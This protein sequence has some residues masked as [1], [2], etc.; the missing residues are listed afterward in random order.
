[1]EYRDEQNKMAV[2]DLNEI[3]TIV[4][5]FD[6]DPE[7]GWGLRGDAYLWNLLQAKMG[8]CVP[9]STA[10]GLCRLIEDIYEKITG[11]SVS[12]SGRLSDDGK[13]EDP[14]SFFKDVG[15]SSPTWGAKINSCN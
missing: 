12:E 15:G 10:E 5:I 7:C 1:M 2:V 3:K 13:E 9:P 11:V 4:T 8:S 14:V 6:K